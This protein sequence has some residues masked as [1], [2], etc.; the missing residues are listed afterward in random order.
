METNYTILKC[1]H[2][3]A[4]YTLDEIFFPK[5]ITGKSKRPY[6]DPTGKIL[7]IDLEE[8][9]DLVESFNCDYCNKDFKVTLEIKAKSSNVSEEL[10]FTTDRVS[11]F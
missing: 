10:D 8:E 3:G 9:Q 5:S 6:K 11:L 4:E 1:P 2:C 7:R